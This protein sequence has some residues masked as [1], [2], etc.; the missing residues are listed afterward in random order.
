M[1]TF[2]FFTFIVSK[3]FLVESIDVSPF[4]DDFKD[5]VSNSN[6]DFEL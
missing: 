4:I 3:F 5:D 1:K 2:T 6:K